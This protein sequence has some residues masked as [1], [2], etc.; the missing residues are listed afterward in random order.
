[1][2]YFSLHFGLLSGIPDAQHQI[3]ICSRDGA[4]KGAWVV[5]G[6]VLCLHLLLACGFMLYFFHVPPTSGGG[7]GPTNVTQVVTQVQ[8]QEG[9]LVQEQEASKEEEK[10]VK[11]SEK[12]SVSQGAGGGVDQQSEDGGG[13]KLTEQVAEYKVKDEEEGASKKQAT[14]KVGEMEKGNDQSSKAADSG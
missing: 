10:P 2:L 11:E 12:R 13:D 14:A 5:M 7:A 4:S 9:G 3:I 6:I 8:Q 1:M